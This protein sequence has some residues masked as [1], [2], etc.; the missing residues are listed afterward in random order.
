M[1]TAENGWSVKTPG[2]RVVA[3]S[4]GKRPGGLAAKAGLPAGQTSAQ[5]G[6]RPRPY[7][8]CGASG[9]SFHSITRLSTSTFFR[10]NILNRIPPLAPRF[11][12][13]L[14]GLT[15]VKHERWQIAVRKGGGMRIPKK[16]KERFFL[17]DS[18]RGQDNLSLLYRR[19]CAY[20]ASPLGR[21]LPCS[22]SDGSTEGGKGSLV[23][24]EHGLSTPAHSGSRVPMTNRSCSRFVM[25]GPFSAGSGKSPGLEEPPRAFVAERDGNSRFCPPGGKRLPAPNGHE[26]IGFSSS[27]ENTP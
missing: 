15:S 5:R 11:R 8:H 3:S 26:T 27:P 10:A 1:R 9:N 2:A 21:I 23:A 22:A 6:G 20:T 24:R 12:T 4:S 25:S 17:L 7:R 18:P 16:L 14:A 13:P 19:L